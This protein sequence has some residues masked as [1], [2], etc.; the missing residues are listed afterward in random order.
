MGTWECRNI[1]GSPPPHISLGMIFCL[2]RSLKIKG[3]IKRDVFYDLQY[4]FMANALV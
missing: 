3:E 2:G 4:F 1:A